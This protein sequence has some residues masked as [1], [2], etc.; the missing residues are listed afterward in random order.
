MRLHRPREILA[1]NDRAFGGDLQPVPHAEIAG[2]PECSYR[3]KD[4]KKRR[5]SAKL[6]TKGA[7]DRTFGLK[8]PVGRNKPVK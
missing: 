2:C 4:E 5:Y 7:P 8:S 3:D 6:W 1:D